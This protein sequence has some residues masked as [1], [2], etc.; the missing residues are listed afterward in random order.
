[1]LVQYSD[2]A[3]LFSVLPEINRVRKPWNQGS[4]RCFDD[5][6]KALRTVANS[7]KRRFYGVKKLFAK[8]CLLLFIPLA[9][10]DDVCHS[11]IR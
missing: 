7:I 10:F 5:D 9:G 8:P 6:A 11:A 4:A 2:Y 3:K 1:M